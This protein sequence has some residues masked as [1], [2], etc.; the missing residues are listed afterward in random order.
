MVAGLAG[1]LIVEAIVVHKWCKKQEE[2]LNG[3]ADKIQSVDKGS[4][5][6]QAEI[7]QKA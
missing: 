2:Y 4:D 5:K 6:N 7:K 1:L 3:Q